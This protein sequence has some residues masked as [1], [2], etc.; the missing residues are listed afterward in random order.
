MYYPNYYPPITLQKV[1]PNQVSLLSVGLVRTNLYGNVKSKVK[2]KFLV[3][4]HVRISKSGRTFKKG[5][6]PDWTK[7]SSPFSKESPESVQPTSWQ[8]ILEEF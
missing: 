5:Y 7:R 8:M 4:D 2:F 3:V 1:T 6:L